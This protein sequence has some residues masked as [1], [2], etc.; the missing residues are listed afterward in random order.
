MVPS[1]ENGGSETERITQTHIAHDFLYLVDCRASNWCTCRGWENM[2]NKQ[3][4]RRISHAFCYFSPDGRTAYPDSKICNMEI[5]WPRGQLGTKMKRTIVR[6]FSNTTKNVYQTNLYIS[7]KKKIPNCNS[8]KQK[9]TRGCLF[10]TSKKD[11]K[12]IFIGQNPDSVRGY[13]INHI[14]YCI[15][16]IYLSNFHALQGAE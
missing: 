4:K 13:V 3:N 12:S 10:Q 2:F 11:G 6:V 16:T 1:E 15:V 8:M 7:Q 14:P 5:I 9:E